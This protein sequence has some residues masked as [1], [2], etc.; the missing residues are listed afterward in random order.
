MGVF[1]CSGEKQQGAEQE[2]RFRGEVVFLGAG[3]SRVVITRMGNWR[4]FKS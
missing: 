4:D 3:F 2:A 1:L